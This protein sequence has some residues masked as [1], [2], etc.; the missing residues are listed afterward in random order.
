MRTIFFILQKEFLQVFRNKSMLPII[1]VVPVVQLLVLAF[2][3]NYEIRDLSIDIVDHDGG[4]WSQQLKGKLLSSGYFRLNAQTGDDAAFEDLETNKADLILTIPNIS[5]GIWYATAKRTYSC[6]SMPS[7]VAK[8]AWRQGMP[9][10]SSAI[11]TAASAL[12]G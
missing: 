10:A 1:F 11:S 5:S 3:A 8:Q 6:W 9:K 4:N 7:T 2:A 12:T